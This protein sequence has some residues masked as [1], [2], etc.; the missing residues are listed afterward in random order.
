[1]S[2]SSLSLGHLSHQ[3]VPMLPPSHLQSPASAH[4]FKNGHVSH[5]PD[6]LKCITCYVLY[7][8]TFNLLIRHMITTLW[9]GISILHYGAYFLLPMSSSS[10]WLEFGFCCVNLIY[11]CHLVCRIIVIACSS[12][13]TV[14]TVGLFFI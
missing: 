9:D 10:L 11:S 7:H 6:T 13:N 2:C 4:I 14:P 5:P 3:R 1:M 8:V 12:V